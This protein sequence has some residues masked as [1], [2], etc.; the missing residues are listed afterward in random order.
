M[1]SVSAVEQSCFQ[2]SGSIG[3]EIFTVFTSIPVISHAVV[4][5]VEA[6][7]NPTTGRKYGESA[8]G[9]TETPDIP[10]NGVHE[11]AAAATCAACFSC[12]VPELRALWLLVAMTCT[13]NPKL[14]TTTIRPGSANHPLTLHPL[15]FRPPHRRLCQGRDGLLRPHRGQVP[16]RRALVR[17]RLRPAQWPLAVHDH[18]PVGAHLHRAPQ[19]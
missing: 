19:L 17:T 15:P 5:A 9:T 7:I 14:E 4:Q 6:L 11:S 13:L 1:V 2:E 8:T 18:Q 3:S 12:R 16:R 10:S